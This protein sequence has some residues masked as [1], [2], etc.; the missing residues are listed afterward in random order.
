MHQEEQQTQPAPGDQP[1]SRQ[2]V[3]PSAARG[4]MTVVEAGQRGGQRVREKYGPA[5]YQAIGQK[6]GSTVKAQR[7]PAFYQAIGQKGGRAV[8]EQRGSEF[9]RQ[10]GRRGGA[11]LVKQYPAEHFWT[12][13]KKGGDTVKAR[14]GGDFYRRIAHQRGATRQPAEDEAAL[15]HAFDQLA[16]DD[17]PATPPKLAA[18]TDWPLSRVRAVLKRVPWWGPAQ[19]QAAQ[20]AHYQRLHA[21]LKDR[22]YP[23]V[24]AMQQHPPVRG[25]RLTLEQVQ[26]I[27]RELA[28]GTTPAT[29]AHQVGV[30]KNTVYSLKQ[31]R[32]LRVEQPPR[33]KAPDDDREERPQVVQIARDEATAV[34]HLSISRALWRALGAPSHLRLTRQGKR[35]A[36]TLEA[37]SAGEGYPVEQG[38]PLVQICIDGQVWHAL[39]LLP[40][41]QY[42]AVKAPHRVQVCISDYPLDL[43]AEMLTLPDACAALH[44]SRQRLSQLIASGSLHAWYD[45]ERK[46]LVTL[47]AAVSARS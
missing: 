33:D 23:G 18:L 17:P 8:K 15:R 22:G 27:R 26:E 6:G 2:S 11:A 7:G 4:A 14:Y 12:A 1:S 39:G 46:Q 29:I 40:G 38:E 31:G 25:R 44:I 19:R 35:H 42:A 3:E 5:F 30:H 10:I 47:R 34:V 13:G 36:L 24:Q 21:L 37:A 28:Q 41:H 45:A 20:A 43:A 9:Y 32:T 16:H